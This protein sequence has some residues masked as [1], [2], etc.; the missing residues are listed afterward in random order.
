MRASRVLTGTILAVA[1]WIQWER[2]RDF[3][4]PQPSVQVR[5][6][7][8]A[9]SETVRTNPENVTVANATPARDVQGR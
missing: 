9:H 2:D 5:Q 7:T 3:S 1:C 6:Q 8:S 4:M